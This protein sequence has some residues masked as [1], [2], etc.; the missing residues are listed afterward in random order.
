MISLITKS[1]FSLPKRMQ[2]ILFR[3]TP[4]T[5]DGM[6]EDLEKFKVP[7]LHSSMRFGPRTLCKSTLNECL[8]GSFIGGLIVSCCSGIGGHWMMALQLHYPVKNFV[9]TAHKYTFWTKVYLWEFFFPHIYLKSSAL[10]PK[11]IFSIFFNLLQNH[12]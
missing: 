10:I 6:H 4:I 8:L 1:P 3:K 11:K 5:S 2:V 9:Q 12:H 7:I